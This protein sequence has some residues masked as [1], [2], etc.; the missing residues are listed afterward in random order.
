MSKFPSAVTVVARVEVDEVESGI[1]TFEPCVDSLSSLIVQEAGIFPVGTYLR[2]TVLKILPVGFHL[3][4]DLGD[5]FSYTAEV[6]L[7]ENLCPMKIYLIGFRNCTSVLVI[8]ASQSRQHGRSESG[9]ENGVNILKSI[10]K[11]PFQMGTLRETL[12]EGNEGALHLRQNDLE[13]FLTLHLNRRIG[14]TIHDYYVWFAK[15]I[16]DM[17]N[18][19]MTMSRMQLNSKFINNMLLEWGRFVTAVKLNRGL[20]DSNYDQL[21]AY[22][23]QHEHY[24]L[25]STT[26]PST[27]VQPHLADTNQLDSRLS[28]MDN[29]IKNLTNT[30]AL[31]TQSYKTYIPQTNNQLQ[32]SS[33]P[34]NHATIQDDKVFIQNVEDMGTMHGV[35]VQL[36]MG[37]LKTELE[38]FK[39]KMLLMQAQ[40]NGVTLDEEQLLFIAT[41]Q[42]NVVDDD[43]PT[44]Q[45]LFMANLSFADPVYDEPGPSYDSD[46]LSEKENQYLEEFL[47]MKALKEKVED[48]LFK[49]DQSLQTVHAKATKP[50]KALMV[51]PPD[52]PI[53]LVPKNNREVHLDY[54]KHF[55]ES[56]ATICEIVE[57]AKV[58]RP[59]DR[60]VASACLYTKH[61]QELLE[62]VIGTCSKDFN[63]RD[64]K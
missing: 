18:I 13:S 52:T 3:R 56:V 59:L 41:R 40:E 10:D 48:K 1:S 46:V 36:V 27:Y 54:L 4:S 32:T 35:Q 20:R 25:S 57:E 33:N 45:T 55:K 42:D 61:S 51:Y 2:P 31:L 30:L 11:G 50:I 37:E 44:A 15:L 7:G 22:L 38:Y 14:E 60:S 16:N 29:L 21:Y 8:E 47:D 58:E 19:K 17:R 62:Y 63:K 12:T 64:K 6:L 34:R 24:P 26:S 5:V 43:A 28:L 9:K 49:Q 23:K 53:K 39:D